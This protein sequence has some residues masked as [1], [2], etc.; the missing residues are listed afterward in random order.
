MGGIDQNNLSR[1]Y[2]RAAA[3]KASDRINRESR[4]RLSLSSSSSDDSR[5]SDLDDD[6]N[7]DRPSGTTLTSKIKSKKQEVSSDDSDF[8]VQAIVS[9][10]KRPGQQEINFPS[11]ATS[12]ASAMASDLNSRPSTSVVKIPLKR[13]Q[14]TL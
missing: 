1:T 6:P 12:T 9:E 5:I 11:L 4:G 2:R 3:S 8:Q 13:K 10:K 14:T 7:L